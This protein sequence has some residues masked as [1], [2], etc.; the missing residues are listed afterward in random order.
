MSIVDEFLKYTHLLYNRGHLT[1]LSGNVSVVVGE[2]LIVTPTSYPKPFLEPGDLVWIN[3]NGEVVRGSRKPTSEWRMHVAIYKRRSDVR[4]V[5][6]THD[7]LPVLLAD[8]IDASLLS[9]AEAYLGSGISIVPY[10]PPGTAELAEA[11][12]AALEKANVAILKRHGVVAVGRDLAEA[13]N[14]I[15]VVADLAKA[16]FYKTLMDIVELWSVKK[17][18]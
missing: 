14:R 17:G 3:F 7:V 2:L 13:V 4:A 18:V 16:T 8:R 11:V 9:E 15:E 10:L 1:L 5:V 12:A 6:H